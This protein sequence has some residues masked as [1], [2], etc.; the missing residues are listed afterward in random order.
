M[1]SKGRKFVDETTRSSAFLVLIHSIKSSFKGHPTLL[2]ISIECFVTDSEKAQG[3]KLVPDWT[4]ARWNNP[5][6]NLKV[7]LR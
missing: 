7:I 4:I 1:R 5:G 6:T 2:A 3:H